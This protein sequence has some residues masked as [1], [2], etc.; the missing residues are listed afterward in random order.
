M[1]AVPLHK[2]MPNP[3]QPR[4]VFN[5][6]TLVE[7]ALSIHENG[8]IQPIVVEPDKNSNRYI[9]HGGERRWR[10]SCALAVA[11][12][13]AGKA[14]NGLAA[15]LKYAS[16]LIA[17]ADPARMVEGYREILSASP[18]IE[19]VLA[20]PGKNL[21][22][23]GLV[24]NV[25]REDLSVLEVAEGYEAL[26]VQGWT[27]QRIA[28]AV[29]KSRAHVTNALR[30]LQLPAEIRE[31][32]ANGEISERQA[33]ALLP[34]YQLPEPTQ[35]AARRAPWGDVSYLIEQARKGVSS[36]G[37][38]NDV[39]H[40]INRVTRDLED[41]PFLDREFE[42][43]GLR[44]P[45]CTNCPAKVKRGK[46]GRCGDDDCY[47]RKKELW[48]ALRIRLA[49][50]ASGLPILDAEEPWIEINILS[51]SLAGQ[52]VEQGCPKLA[53]RYD[54]FL[55]YGQRLADFPD[56]RI[57]CHH[58][59]GQ[60]CRC[61]AALKREQAKNDPEKQAE[62]EAK[63]RLEN[64]IVAPAA[65]VLLD[66]LVEGDAGAWRL[67]LPRMAATYIDQAQDWSLEKIQERI[68]RAMVLDAVPWNGQ[69]NLDISLRKVTERLAQAGLSLPDAPDGLALIER[70]LERVAGWVATFEE[71]VPTE[72]QLGG[73]IRNINDLV[74]ELDE[75]IEDED[76]G[77]ATRER[78]EMLLESAGRSLNTIV[79]VRH[80]LL[81][82]VFG[83]MDEEER[84]V[85]IKEVWSQYK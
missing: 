16:E 73:N 9:L 6:E 4:K 11:L 17:K 61:L 52:I 37:I 64:E 40:L 53:L 51:D 47:D 76:T 67:M 63:K 3:S 36:T 72:A 65:R 82:P 80:L 21:L 60:H 5:P 23:R 33:Q 18:E 78:C 22:V 62:N 57:V 58:G 45:Q 85:K 79:D 7:L 77:E 71:E 59:K 75:I 41:C 43:D 84:R 27:H 20:E 2:I 69:H 12:S 83:T 70:Q 14:E 48:A 1:N 42:A 31:P 28:E 34:V 81:N 44:S 39:N 8:L 56:V 15:E 46:S 25:Q 74:D 10:A 29:G 68:A 50:E 49:A 35:E 26:R 66:A 38:R 19:V 54:P 13:R 32:L 30:L 24:E 55:G